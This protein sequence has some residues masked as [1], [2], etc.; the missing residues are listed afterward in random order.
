MVS[1][2]LDHT[3][4]VS[5]QK[6]LYGMGSN[7]YGQL[8]LPVE[9]RNFNFPEPILVQPLEKFYI[10]KIAAGVQFS[11][12]LTE[13]NKLYSWGRGDSGQLGTGVVDSC[14]SPLV[15]NRHISA[16]IG[17]LRTGAGMS[18]VICKDG[19]AFGCGDNSQGGLGLGEAN[20]FSKLT[21]IEGLSGR[22]KDIQVGNSHSMF[23]QADGKLMVS[24]SNSHGQ[25]GSKN[26]KFS[27]SLVPCGLFPKSNVH[28]IACG[29]Y[30]V[31]TTTSNEIF[32]WGTHLLTSTRHK[33]ECRV[34]N[35]LLDL[36]NPNQILANV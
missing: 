5:D 4:L 13:E 35:P 28:L 31:C 34:C 11:L 29:A 20:V 18:F 22:I 30:S 23:L 8:G 3:L 10:N 36:C 14:H 2:G 6:Q 15:C 32:I 1:C 26:V 12:A 7:Q 24:G 25:L 9:E 19:S 17:E 33:Y 16:E 21:R 27:K